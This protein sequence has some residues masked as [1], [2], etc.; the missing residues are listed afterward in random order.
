MI[1]EIKEQVFVIPK[2]NEC[3]FVIK[4]TSN[5]FQNFPIKFCES[6]L[7]KFETFSGC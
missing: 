5:K 2:I 3:N 1:K 6:N 4:T 7:G